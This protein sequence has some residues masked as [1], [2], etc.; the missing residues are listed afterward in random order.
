MGKNM[1]K[2]TF[3]TFRIHLTKYSVKAGTLPLLEIQLIGDYI[4]N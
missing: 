3:R 4:V 2:K 1:G